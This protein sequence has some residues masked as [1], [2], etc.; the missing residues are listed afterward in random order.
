M[1]HL[2]FDLIT[3]TSQNLLEFCERMEFMEEIIGEK[4]HTEVNPKTGQTGG[5][6]RLC[7]QPKSSDGGAYS[8]NFKRQ[9]TN[10]NN[11]LNYQA[12]NGYEN[13]PHRGYPNHQSKNADYDPN[14]FRELHNKI[15]HDLAGCMEMKK[16]AAKMRAQW[17]TLKRAGGQGDRPHYLKN[18]DNKNLH[19]MI[20]QAVNESFKQKQKRYNAGSVHFASEVAIMPEKKP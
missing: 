14:K 15:G 18:D 11:Y 1:V 10:N 5:M 20:Q 2:G 16:Q 8:N 7:A 17:M 13:Q 3:A 12:R 6:G 4:S 9:K 19:A